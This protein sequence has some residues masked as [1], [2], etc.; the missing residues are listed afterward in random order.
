[1]TKSTLRDD[2]VCNSLLASDAND[3][4]LP[5]SIEAHNGVVDRD[6][7]QFTDLNSPQLFPCLLCRKENVRWD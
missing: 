6:D 1:M 2:L 7:R 3:T 5:P 4:S